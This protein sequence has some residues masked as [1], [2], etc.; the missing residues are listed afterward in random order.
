VTF[1]ISHPGRD[2]RVKL[3]SAAERR[4]RGQFGKHRGFG[5]ELSGQCVD[6]LPVFVADFEKRLEPPS[7][8]ELG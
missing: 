2:T 6:R 4:D 8:R 1:K 3:F 5:A 7:A